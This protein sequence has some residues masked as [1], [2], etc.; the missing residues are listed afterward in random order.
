MSTTPKTTPSSATL[1]STRGAE[2]RV[3]MN[4]GSEIG[5]GFRRFI[6]NASD[7]ALAAMA[8][9]ARAK[10]GTSAFD[11]QDA[12]ILTELRRREESR[13]TLPATSEVAASIADQTAARAHQSIAPASVAPVSPARNSAST[14]V[15]LDAEEATPSSGDRH[16]DSTFAVKN[17]ARV[18]LP[19]ITRAETLDLELSTDSEQ[20]FF[21]KPQV[22]EPE[23]VEQY[24]V[25]TPKGRLKAKLA[26]VASYGERGVEVKGINEKRFAVNNGV[27]RFFSNSWKAVKAVAST[28]REAIES[29]F[30]PE[31]IL[32]MGSHNKKKE[33]AL[34]TEL[35][36]YRNDVRMIGLGFNAIDTYINTLNEMDAEFIAQDDQTMQNFIYDCRFNQE[37][38]HYM[39]VRD[40]V[41]A[42]L[43]ER[44]GQFNAKI[45]ALREEK[46]ITFDEVF[47]KKPEKK[48][49]VKK[50]TIDQAKLDQEF[51]NSLVEKLF[52]NDKSAKFQMIH[53]A[54]FLE[55]YGVSR[56]SAEQVAASLRG[57]VNEGEYFE[58]TM[59]T[60]SETLNKLGVI[61]AQSEQENQAAMGA[62]KD[63]A[64]TIENLMN[65]FGY[66][67]KKA[68][69]V[70]A[71]I[72]AK[73]EAG[74]ET[75]LSGLARTR[76]AFYH[77]IKIGMDWFFEIK[78]PKVSPYLLKDVRT[79][80]EVG[81]KFDKKDF[82]S[83]F[84][85]AEPIKAEK[86][87]FFDKYG[88]WALALT[89]LVAALGASSV[90]KKK[91]D[92][93]KG[94][95]NLAQPA[96]SASAAS[97]MANAP[98]APVASSAEVASPAPTASAT[99]IAPAPTASAVAIADLPKV[100][101]KGSSGKSGTTTNAGQ[102]KAKSTTVEKGEKPDVPKGERPQPKATEKKADQPKKAPAV[103]A[104]KTPT[105]KATPDKKVEK[106]E[107][108][109]DEQVLTD[110][111]KSDLVRETEIK[112]EAYKV[113]FEK[114]TAD[115]AI[116]AQM[117]DIPI[118][119]SQPN[120]EKLNTNV[121]NLLQTVKQLKTKGDIKKLKDANDKVVAALSEIE[122]QRRLEVMRYYADYGTMKAKFAAGRVK[123]AR[124]YLH[125]R[126]P[127][128]TYSHATYKVNPDK[129]E[130]KT[131]FDYNVDL[132]AIEAEL[133][134]IEKDFASGK[135]SEKQ[136]LFY[137]RRALYWEGYMEFINHHLYRERLGQHKAAFSFNR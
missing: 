53:L 12:A 100:G 111:E 27:L 131:T 135:V 1:P 128:F 69:K 129:S 78:E 59:E 88:K 91:H 110:A 72:K 137:L 104:K 46:A 118:I 34:E 64:E 106:P 60:F 9:D 117:K 125:G 77:G 113:R 51:R 49:A 94:E 121:D 35:T 17:G 20:E 30:F 74:E 82:S 80:D 28:G 123:S 36:Q 57:S 4:L 22:T 24:L 11:A 15:L 133:Q 39:R 112:V 32:V 48:K 103:A 75:G 62:A 21:T 67:E 127:K 23:L 92:Q 55:H 8:A 7:N 115:I 6:T 108:N 130:V 90:L 70:L 124:Q 96:A 65:A 56:A 58:V 99:D 98:I 45:K 71:E 10:E 122:A 5:E 134:Q 43:I 50:E 14:T 13:Q 79:N 37:S 101:P 3:D 76:M 31:E 26:E 63:E 109:V 38:E 95:N 16:P 29:A 54:N 120:K 116:P 85:P 47:G 107:V 2:Q 41:H 81:V 93:I 84:Y 42:R 102:T 136:G 25:G 97:S 61:K 18:S 89:G 83:E 68:K 19:G 132:D 40:L 66:N 119:Y 73:R 126:S 114:A 105:P 86:R 52:T 33:A 87:S 44:Q